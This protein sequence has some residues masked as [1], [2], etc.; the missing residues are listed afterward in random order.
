[1]DSIKLRILTF[2]V[3]NSLYILWLAIGLLT[4]ALFL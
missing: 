4:G 3:D 1:M 2:L